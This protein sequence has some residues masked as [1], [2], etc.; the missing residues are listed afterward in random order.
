M[1][2]F[3]CIT[4]KSVNNSGFING[5]GGPMIV[6][7]FSGERATAYSDRNKVSVSRFNIWKGSLHL[8]EQTKYLRAYGRAVN[9]YADDAA[10]REIERKFVVVFSRG[11]NWS[12][13]SMVIMPRTLPRFKRNCPLLLLLLFFL[14]FF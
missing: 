6:Y 3:N 8:V 1:S 10:G 5:F 14:L 4:I 2:S 11:V 7:L 9:K 12:L 13:L